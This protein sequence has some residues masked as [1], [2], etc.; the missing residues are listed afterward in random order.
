[1]KLEYLV[2]VPYDVS[3]C[4]TKADF[5]NFLKIDSLISIEGN[6][7]SYRRASE[8][9]NLITANFRVETDNI[10]S[11]KER[12]FLIVLENKNDRLVDE[13]SELG[14][15]IRQIAKR[16]NPE[17]TVINTLW[18]DIGRHYAKEAYPCFLI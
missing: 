1:M 17:S 8:S 16:I 14:E 4:N 15:K 11:C 6:K 13:F 3:F 7:L 12:Y 9:K 10:P 5:I 18:D 2:L